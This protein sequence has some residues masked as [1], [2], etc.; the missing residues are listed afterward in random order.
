MAQK[1]LIRQ[2]TASCNQWTEFWL[3]RAGVPQGSILGQLLFLVFI[4][5]IIQT[6]SHCN[7]RLFADVTCIFIQVKDQNQAAEM[8]SEDL[9]Y[10]SD[11]S[12]LQKVNVE[13]VV[14]SYYGS[15][16]TYQIENS[17]L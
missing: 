14:N 16:I 4:N 7:V 1:L 9:A 6:I 12:K 17:E 10:F 15:N 2:K 5:D 8:I 13:L 11:W 3:E